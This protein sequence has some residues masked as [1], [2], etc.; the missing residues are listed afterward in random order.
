MSK[1]KLTF[2]L[3]L[4]L[5]CVAKAEVPTDAKK[6]GDDVAKTNKN[7]I[8]EREVA[9]AGLDPH[10]G[11]LLQSLDLDFQVFTNFGSNPSVTMWTGTL[12]HS[13]ALGHVEPFYRVSLTRLD[14]GITLLNSGDIRE[15]AEGSVLGFGVGVGFDLNIVNILEVEPGEFSPYVGIAVGYNLLQGSGGRDSSISDQDI[16]E[17][18]INIIG[19]EVELGGKYFVT[20]RLA[21]K[22]ALTCE[23][24]F[25]ATVRE[26]E[27]DDTVQ[28][29]LTK[30]QGFNT[31]NRSFGAKVGMILYF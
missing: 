7:P 4:F 24:I 31:D 16:F 27:G 5:V 23:Q 18:G 3:I 12:D 2:L 22:M 19:V 26:S 25:Y 8:V 15:G 13:F 1:F 10:S 14:V 20:N 6:A 30:L 17:S 29:D 9:H 21:L 28:F 11:K